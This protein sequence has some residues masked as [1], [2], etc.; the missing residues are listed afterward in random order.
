MSCPSYEEFVSKL[1]SSMSENVQLPGEESHLKML[2]GS[3]HRLLASMEE[4]KRKQPKKSA[5]CILL[6]PIDD[7]PHFCLTQRNSYDGVHS[8]EVCFP[9]GSYDQ[10]DKTLKNTALRETWEEIGVVRSEIEIIARL[11]DLYIPPSNFLVSPFI[12]I[13]SYTPTFQ[14][15]PREVESVINVPVA[16][17]LD[18]S[19]VK[20]KKIPTAGKTM[21]AP[22]FDFYDKH[23]W[24]A[25]AGILSELK[26]IISTFSSTSSL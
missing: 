2:P 10:E 8:G 4:V 16:S 5:V 11:T 23:V 6:Y 22:Y 20:S 1:K 7:V 13:C 21:D 14:P 18:E 24:G 12:G 25:T 26:A 17:L 19:L 3:R 9:G 15:D